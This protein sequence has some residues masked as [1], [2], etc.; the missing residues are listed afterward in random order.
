MLDTLIGHYA[1]YRFKSDDSNYNPSMAIESSKITNEAS[2]VLTVLFPPWRG[3][4]GAYDLLAK[5]LVKSGSAV[6]NYR[7]HRQILEAN[8]SRVLESF[9]YIQESVVGDIKKLMDAHSYDKVNF[10]AS[11]LGNVSMAKVAKE[12]KDFDTATMIVAG[13]N[14]ARCTWEGS[15]TRAIRQAFED[16]GIDEDALDAAWATIAPKSAASA[17]AGKS[18]RMI[19][20]GTDSIIPSTYQQEM[21]EA[22]S[23][24]AKELNIARTN[25]GHIATVARYCMSGEVA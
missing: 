4:E 20:S 18:V 10:I 15:R 5:R 21:V 11:S 22:V 23:P 9:S 16:Q 13:S 3:G 8:T 19:V 25:T 6:L 14:L 12:F 1:A 2:P 17:F 7:F 24:Y